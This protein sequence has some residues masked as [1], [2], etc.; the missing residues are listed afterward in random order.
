MNVNKRL[1]CRF[2][3]VSVET[4]VVPV[5]ATSPNPGS[6]SK[7][8]EHRPAAANG[9]LRWGLMHHNAIATRESPYYKRLIGKPINWLPIMRLHLLLQLAFQASRSELGKQSCFPLQGRETRLSGTLGA[10]GTN[11]KTV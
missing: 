9:R 11:P 5:A 10:V 7:A 4:E 2:P 1:N 3:T 8:V 6:T